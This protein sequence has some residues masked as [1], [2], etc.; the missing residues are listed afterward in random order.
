[1]IVAIA[2][3]YSCAEHDGRQAKF[4][5]STDAA[6]EA[7]SLNEEGWDADALEKVFEFARTHNSS[8]L[9]ILKNGR[10]LASRQWKLQNP[11]VAGQVGYRDIWYHGDS[12]DGWAREDVASTQK[13][14][15]A[16]LAGIARDKGLL[17][18]DDPV[19]TYL[20]IGWSQTNPEQ[21]A[22]IT[23]RH[24]LSMTSGVSEELEFVFSAGEEWSYINKAYSLVNDVIQA[25]SGKEPDEFTREWLTEPLGMTHTGWIVRSEF[26]RQW[27]TNGLVTTAPDLAR[28]GLLIQ[29]GGRWKDETIISHDS[30][31]QVLSPSSSFNPSYGLLWWL[32]NPEG[33]RWVRN[34]DKVT[35]GL[36]I[37][38]APK[39]LVAAMGTSERRCYVV[40]SHDLVITR[41]GSTWMLDADGDFVSSRDFDRQLWALL[42]AAMPD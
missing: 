7:V 20:D 30:L 15:I 10:L 35:P 24:L 11:L 6:W 28:F 40:P 5:P 41:T 22:N 17:V 27:N 12:D 37:A 9:V 34:S 26:F 42:A 25:A 19:S 32:N 3:T 4:Y 13:S 21:E 38:D 33:W 8:G 16:I 14:V 31:D 18:F 1:M 36:M 23:V 29:S 39:D 2:T